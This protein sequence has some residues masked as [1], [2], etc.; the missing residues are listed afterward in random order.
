MLILVD[1]VY[2]SNDEI[3]SQRDEQL[4]IKGGLQITV[5]IQYCNS[6]Y[7]SCCGSIDATNSQ[8]SAPRPGFMQDCMSTLDVLYP[9]RRTGTVW[10]VCSVYTLTNI[11][12][13]YVY[14]R[15]SVTLRLKHTLARRVVLLLLQSC[16]CK[17][18]NC[19]PLCLPS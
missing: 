12:L 4:G 17:L 18:S 14:R 2:F 5:H 1:Y 11:H 15:K 13:A 6:Y 8:F 10:Y 19:Q 3:Y 7:R 16:D 9:E